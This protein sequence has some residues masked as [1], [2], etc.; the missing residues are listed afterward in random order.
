[1]RKYQQII[2]SVILTVILLGLA[3]WAGRDQPVTITKPVVIVAR[4]V[5]AGKQL[6]VED[7]AMID[8]PESSVQDRYLDDPA[9]VMDWWTTDS[10]EAGEILM[11]SKLTR[12]PSGIIYPNPGKGRR[13][14]TIELTPGAANGFHLAPGNR[15]DLIIVPRQSS[16]GLEPTQTIQDIVVVDLI[17]AKAE[18]NTFMPAS[19]PSAPL[20]CLDLS[21]GQAQ[22]IAEAKS[23][24]DIQIAVINEPADMR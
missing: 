18:A 4:E 21:L 7:L 22:Q 8:M 17:G 24:A 16:S 14:M 2:L 11:Q 1:M 9:T 3:Y 19:G 6:T 10:L 20:L 13:L 12:Q 15:V 5:Q 23:R